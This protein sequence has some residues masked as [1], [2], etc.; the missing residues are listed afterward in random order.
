[1]FSQGYTNC[2]YN[3]LFQKKK[4]YIYNEVTVTG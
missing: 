2:K 4:L 3:F 1:M